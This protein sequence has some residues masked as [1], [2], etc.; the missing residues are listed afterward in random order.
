MEFN[1]KSVSDNLWERIAFVV[2]LD[3]DPAG[4]RGVQKARDETA[5]WA[6]F[7]LSSECPKLKDWNDDLIE[8]AER[9]GALMFK[10]GASL[11]Q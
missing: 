3:R 7:K 6:G 5:D 4:Q 10:E 9:L 1:T 11:R 8:V 2:A